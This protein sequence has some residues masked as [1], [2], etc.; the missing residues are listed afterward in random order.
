MLSSSFK[1]YFRRKTFRILFFVAVLLWC[2][3][4]SSQSLF[5]N[6]GF[7]VVSYPILKST[8]GAVCHQLSVKTFSFMGH[9]LFVCARCTGIYL[10]ALLTSILSLLFF[11]KLKLGLKLLYVSVLPVMLDVL[12]SSIHVYV[13]SKYIAFLTG[14]FFGSVVFL[15]IL[16]SAEN[17]FYKNRMKDN[18]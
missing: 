18:G 7:A 11:S 6:T 13:Y 15:Y 14:L 5:S 3:G 8:Y 9:K 1:D 12:L 16:E 10:G 17:Y 4:F 2:I